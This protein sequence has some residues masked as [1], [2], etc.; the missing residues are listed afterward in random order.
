MG[1]EIRREER[2]KIVSRGTAEGVMDTVLSK[3]TSRTKSITPGLSRADPS[4]ATRMLCIRYE[5]VCEQCAALVS[6]LHITLA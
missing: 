4:N 1:G 3:F 6:S 5:I 2:I